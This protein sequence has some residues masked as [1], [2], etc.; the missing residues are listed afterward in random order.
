MSNK[1]ATCQVRLQADDFV[2]LRSLARYGRWEQGR[3]LMWRF[4][5][6]EDWASVQ[7]DQC[8]ALDAAERLERAGLVEETVCHC[9]CRR[10]II[11]LTERGKRFV[12]RID[13]PAT[14]C[15]TPDVSNLAVHPS[16][17]IQETEQLPWPYRVLGA[18]FKRN[19]K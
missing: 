9:G 15:A 4:G 18:I 7:Y 6:D 8:P 16:L 10:E 11:Q 2:A 12:E 17:A 1:V 5:R 14:A 3:W 13:A 19:G